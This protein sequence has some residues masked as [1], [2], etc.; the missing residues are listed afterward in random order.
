[1]E[2]AEIGGR[3]FSCF[4]MRPAMLAGER[5]SRSFASTKIRNSFCPTIFI[6]W[7]FAYFLRTY[8]LCCAFFGSYRLRTL[9]RLNSSEMVE[10]LRP[11]LSEIS[12]S[13]CP[14]RRKMSISCRSLLFSFGAPD[15]FSRPREFFH[16]S[17]IPSV[18]IHLRMWA[19]CKKYETAQGA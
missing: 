17:I 10:T 14:L 19:H 8:A 6:P 18:R 4:C 9:L 1:M 5:P 13:E 7:N 15:F 12:R 16:H 2:S 11:R 3:C